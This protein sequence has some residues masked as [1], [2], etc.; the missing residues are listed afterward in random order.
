MVDPTYPP[1]DTLKPVA[2]DV[3]LVDGPLIRF[4]VQFP[5]RMTIIRIGQDLLIHSPTPLTP[6]L[7]AEVDA[8]G[9]VRWIVG[10]NRIHYW[11]IPE[12][13]AAYPEAEVYLAPKILTQS[14]GRIDFPAH[15]L[16]EERGYPWDQA[17]ATLPVAGKFMTEVVFFHRASRTLVLTD[18][19]ENFEP[20]KLGFIARLIMW[21]GGASGSMPR[22]MRLTYERQTLR[23]AVER[24]LGWAPERI[25]VAHGR[26]F[27][28]GGTTVLERAF[29]WLL[30]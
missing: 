6:S 10:P 4:G 14:K 19:I 28:R 16:R 12:W 25:I 20:R 30:R 18:L 2:P 1:L 24:M 13:H 3:W 23:A 8:L 26:W 7:R 17:I 21:L 5:T 15:E 22:D 11:W 27:E 9:S 29:R